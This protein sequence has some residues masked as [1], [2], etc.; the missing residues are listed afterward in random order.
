[1]KPVAPKKKIIWMKCR[2]AEH[3]EGNHAYATLILSKP[4]VQGGGKTVRYRCTTCNGM[5]Q[6]TT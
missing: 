6:I 5:F 3:C 4:M 2:A 1:M